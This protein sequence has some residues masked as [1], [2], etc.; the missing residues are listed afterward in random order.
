MER[1]LLRSK[2]EKDINNYYILKDM[3]G[4]ILSYLKAESNSV[5]KEATISDLIDVLSRPYISIKHRI[6]VLNQDET[7]DYEIPKDD[8]IE[9]SISFSENLQNGQRK[10]LSFKL[11]NKDGKYT[12]CVNYDYGGGTKSNKQSETIKIFYNGKKYI[13]NST[14]EAYL[15]LKEKEIKEIID[16]DYNT[17]KK[18]IKE[19]HIFQDFDYEY[20]KKNNRR[21]GVHT[22]LW[23][24]SRFSYEIGVKIKDDLYYWF[25]KGIYVLSSADVPGGDTNRE[26]SITLKD[27]FAIFEGNTGKFLY[28]TEVKHS[29]DVEMVIKD[30]LR[31]DTGMG[32]ICD[33]KKPLIDT[34]YKGFKTQTSIR[35]EQ[36][37]TYGSLLSEL[38]TQMNA[39]YYYNDV[40]N[41]VVVPINE[42]MKDEH[43][44]VSWTYIKEKGDMIDISKS[45]DLDSAINIIYVEGNNVETRTY[46]ALVVNNDPRSPFAVGYIGKRVGDSIT[47]CNV[48]NKQ[49]ARDLGVYT[50]RKNTLNCLQLKSEVRFNPLIKIDTLIE[51]EHDFFNY[52][53]TKFIVKDISFSSNQGTMNLSLVDIQSLSFLKVGDGNDIGISE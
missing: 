40:G 23:G 43:K 30:M 9:D 27:K 31:Q 21:F 4:F 25:A 18:Y 24:N 34:S 7:V 49:Q 12:P 15:F 20:I 1:I 48:W 3:N 26:I 8:I 13:F 46:S 10:S 17:F 16:I 50:L 19:K 52:N 11:V 51:I 36:G 28:T 29:T 38:F 39:A 5:I 6:C 41:L 14:G 32:Y 22:P 37:D 45:Y 2:L 53:G 33:S 42:E 44:P 47:D 35:K